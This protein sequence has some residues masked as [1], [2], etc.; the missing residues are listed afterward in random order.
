MTDISD[1]ATERE[2][3]LLSDALYAQTRRAGLQGRTM[4]DSA[5]VCEDCGEPIPQAR[6]WAVPGVQRC[7]DCQ[8]SHERAKRTR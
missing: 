7:I 2:H 4:D 5:Q 1:R 6:R 8:I 3:E